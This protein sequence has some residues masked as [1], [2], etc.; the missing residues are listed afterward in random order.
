MAEQVQ[1]VRI[2]ASRQ[3]ERTRSVD[4]AL[5]VGVNRAV[6]DKTGNLA[7]AHQ[8]V[9]AQGARFQHDGA[10]ANGQV[11]AHALYTSTKPQASDAQSSGVGRAREAGWRSVQRPSA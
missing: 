10:A 2:D 9:G 4:D 6:R 11:E 5:G 8:H 7:T 1:A 3:H